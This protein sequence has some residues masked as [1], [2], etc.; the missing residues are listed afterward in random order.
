MPEYTR[1]E[2]EQQRETLKRHLEALDKE[3]GGNG[4]GDLKAQ[5]TEQEELAQLYDKLPPGELVRLYDD[6]HPQWQ[7]IMDAV[8]MRS[9][10]ESKL[11]RKVGP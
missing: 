6:D 11:F 4:T 9:T 10:R 1:Q 2:K 8:A 5:M 7:K 3:L